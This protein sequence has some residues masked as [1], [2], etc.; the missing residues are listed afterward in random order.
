MIRYLHF[1]EDPAQ[2]GSRTRKFQRI[3][4]HFNSMSSEYG[5]KEHL[6]I[7]EQIISYKGIK[8]SLRQYNPKKPKKWGYKLFLLCGEGG[9][10]HQVE[11]YGQEVTVDP[12]WNAVGK[13]GQIVLRMAK[14]IPEHKNHKLFF[15]NWF[16]SP[17]LQVLLFRKRIQ[18]IGT[19]QLPRAKNLTF[20][21]L[22]E[23]KNERGKVLV[24]STEIEGVRLFATKWIDNRSVHILSTFSAGDP[25]GYI[26]RYDR[27][28]Q[29]HETITVPRAI[30]DYNTHMGHVDEINSYLGRFRMTT[31]TRKRAYIKIILNFVNIMATNA[32]LKYRDDALMLK[33]PKKKLD[34]LSI[35]NLKSRM[36]YQ[37]VEQV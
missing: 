23:K 16:N 34:H 14:S 28:V 11:F 24:K 20:P 4:D 31:Q 25:S 9:I 29:K 35:S 33:E 15:D 18:S 37:I 36:A 27:K 5:M 26:T 3:I 21:E 2:A 19:L 6:S 12:E 30:L 13:S 10:M 1:K 17:M 22:T 8:S 32:W 7:D